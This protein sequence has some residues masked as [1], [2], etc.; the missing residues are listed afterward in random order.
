MNIWTATRSNYVNVRSTDPISLD[1]SWYFP[2]L[3]SQIVK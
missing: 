1:T 2:T 3:L